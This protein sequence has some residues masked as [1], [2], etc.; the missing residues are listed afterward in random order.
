MENIQRHEGRHLFGVDPTR[1]ASARPDYPGELYDRLVQRCGAL[2]ERA[3]FEVGAGTGLATKELLKRG[4]RSIRV[5]EPDPRLAQFLEKSLPS[6]VLTIDVS[7]FEAADLA[8]GSLDL[9]VAATSFHWLEQSSALAKVRGALKPGGWWAMWW[10][11]YGSDVP[12]P[13]YFA[14]ADLLMRVPDSPG[15]AGQRGLPFALDREARVSDL[16]AAGFRNVEVDVLRWNCRYDTA[17]IVALYSTFSPV[18]ALAPQARGELL[19]EIGRMV[20]AEFGGTVDMAFMTILYTAQ[21]P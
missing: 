2:T 7:S 14:I 21:Q 19:G 13:F 10:T 17:R 18:Q 16:V 15:G 3:V 6:D 1:Y 11:H 20:D 12:H 4:A 8:A 5:I 9:G